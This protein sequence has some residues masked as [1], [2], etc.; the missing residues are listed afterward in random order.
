V[1]SIQVYQ[2]GGK[3]TQLIVG[4]DVSKHTLDIAMLQNDQTRYLKV[5]NKLEGFKI[6][7]EWLS[8]YDCQ[9]V[10]VCMEATGQYGNAA[11]DYIFLCGYQVSVVNPARIKAYANS[12]LKRNKTDKSDA[13][14]IAE[15]CQREK[16]GL[17]RPPEPAFKV[18]K[19]LIHELDALM[20][21]K[22]QEHNRQEF[23]ADVPLVDAILH[24]HVEF[25]D[26]KTRLIRQAI[27]ELI[28]LNA[29]LKHQHDLLVSIPGIGEISAARLLAE[30]R[31]FHEF[32]NSRQLTAYAGLNPR[33]F[34][35]G[36]SVN[37]KSRLSKIG[38]ANL[39]HT[40]YMPAMVA[41]THNPIIRTFCQRL[42]DRGLCKMSV[43]GAAMRKLL[44]LA[45]GVIKTD[46]PF[47]PYYAQKIDICS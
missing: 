25:L 5:E 17:W 18:L 44:V 9:E 43:V 22:R 47:D 21:I 28:Q 31:D 11:A 12:R 30:V 4:I 37:R 46:M 35:S 3:V 39:R 15:F 33:Q 24:E 26:E 6:L 38:N 23:S 34:Q 10:H 41:K 40:L 32:S 14:L 1:P 36:I 8:K 20:A 27:H 2:T 16:P 13:L 19:A 42:S 29:R 7:E 45:Y